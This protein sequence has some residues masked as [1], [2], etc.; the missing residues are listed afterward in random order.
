M[1]TAPS[2]RRLIWKRVPRPLSSISSFDR[3]ENQPNASA[4]FG[5]CG[6]FAGLIL[7]AG[8]IATARFGHAL[9]LPA[10]TARDG[11]LV[12]LNRYVDNPIPDIVLTASS[13]TFRL[14]EEH[15]DTPPLTNLAL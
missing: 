2:A 7:V 13:M 14:K 3:M 6:L 8:G 9:Q 12:T 5:K 1:L 4:L 15:F 11:A 10:T